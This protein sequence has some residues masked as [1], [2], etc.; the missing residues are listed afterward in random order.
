VIT[1]YIVNATV[2]ESVCVEYGLCML[3][4]VQRPHHLCY[5]HMWLIWDVHIQCTKW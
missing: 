1:V 4:R 2:T 5:T 3:Q